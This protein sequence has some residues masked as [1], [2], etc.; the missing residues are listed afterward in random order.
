MPQLSSSNTRYN[1]INECTNPDKG[2]F[3]HKKAFLACR[4]C[5]VHEMVKLNLIEWGMSVTTPEENNDNNNNSNNIPK[6]GGGVMGDHTYTQFH[7][8]RIDLDLYDVVIVDVELIHTKVF[9]LHHNNGDD[10]NNNNNNS[11]HNNTLNSSL[12][13]NNNNNNTCIA[14]DNININNKHITNNKYTNIMVF[15]PHRKEVKFKCGKECVVMMRPV[16]IQK[17][18]DALK[19]MF[20]IPD[21]PRLTRRISPTPSSP[22]LLHL[23]PALTSTI[24]L[25]KQLAEKQRVLLVEDNQLNQRVVKRMLEKLGVGKVA[26]AGDG[27]EALDMVIGTILRHEKDGTLHHYAAFD[28]VLMDCQ[29][30]IMDGF[31]AT[32]QIRLQEDNYHSPKLKI[33]ALTAGVSESLRGQCIQAGMDGFLSKPVTSADLRSV[34]IGS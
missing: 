27:K 10:E 34:L 17:L 16:D 5:R 22:S 23:R 11:N 2:I 4:T 24:E 20:D 25:T 19:R 3:A 33:I 13:I 32:R 12:N 7:P 14:G 1:Y 28:L 9:F 8:L 30:P 29:M 15:T 26:V 31:E 6:Y 18:C 21:T